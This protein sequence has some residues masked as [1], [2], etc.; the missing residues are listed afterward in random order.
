LKAKSLRVIR[1]VGG[2][3]VEGECKS[4]K[5]LQEWNDTLRDEKFHLQQ[6][7]NDLRNPPVS[8][9]DVKTLIP[10]PGRG[11]FRTTKAHL[12][13]LML[14]RAKNPVLVIEDESLGRNVID[15]D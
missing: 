2:V 8:K 6:E 9:V 10:I 1:Y 3:F 13:R 15:A 5:V 12:Q 14:Q 11:T 7:L 4:C